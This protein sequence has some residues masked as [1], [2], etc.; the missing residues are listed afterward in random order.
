MKKYKAK[1]MWCPNQ[2][3]NDFNRVCTLLYTFKFD[4]YLNFCYRYTYAK[5]EGERKEGY[6]KKLVS[7]FQDTLVRHF[8]INRETGEN[9][10]ACMV[11]IQN[12]HRLFLPKD[13]YSNFVT[14]I[15][16]ILPEI[17]SQLLTLSE[18]NKDEGVWVY[19]A[20]NN[21]NDKDF[22]FQPDDYLQHVGFISTSY[23]LATVIKN[24]VCD[25]IPPTETL[26]HAKFW[27]L[28]FLLPVGKNYINPNICALDN[29]HE[30]I[31]TPQHNKFKVICS[32]PLSRE[33]L[34]SAYLREHS[35]GHTSCQEEKRMDK[36]MK[37]VSDKFKGTITIV[38]C[39]LIFKENYTLES[40][41]SF[42]VPFKAPLPLVLLS[43][44]IDSIPCKVN[45]FEKEANVF[46]EMIDTTQFHA[47]KIPIYKSI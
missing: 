19:R 29:E 10:P 18:R 34:L 21:L 13:S 40:D 17:N 38:T 4:R 42:K 32:Q 23:R 43:P 28:E 47:V 8:I 11:L 7:E 24:F 2:I 3:A 20:V 36:M 25:V 12:V 30:I 45:T 27:I 6:K 14:K 16:S 26:E 9:D 31:L 44:S 22:V 39:E 37:L 33:H 35:K 46:Y 15:V 5:H 41:L 1:A